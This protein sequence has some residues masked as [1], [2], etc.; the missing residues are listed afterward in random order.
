MNIIENI[1]TAGLEYFNILSYMFSDFLRTCKGQNMLRI[2]AP[3]PEDQRRAG[4]PK[5][6]LHDP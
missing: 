6:T 3:A 4:L 1:A 5:R 2:Y